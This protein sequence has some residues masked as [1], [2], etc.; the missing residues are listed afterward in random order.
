MR[1]KDIVSAAFRLERLDKVDSTN[2]YLK[3]RAAEGAP[4]GL[5]VVAE[6]QT[7]GRGRFGRSFHSPRGKGL[8][9]SILLRPDFLPAQAA[10]LTPWA[11][12][13]VCRALEKVTG[14]KP[15]IKWINDILLE[16]KK[17]CGILT[18]ADITPEGRLGYVIL[19]IGLNLTHGAEDFP[20]EVAHIATSLAQHL[21][22]TPD[23][24]AVL[25]AL[26]SELETMWKDFPEQGE[27]YLEAY[28][29][30]CSTVG[31]EI[32]ITSGSEG[33]EGFALG[34]NED[35]SL[36]VRLTDGSCQNLDSGMVSAR[37]KG[38]T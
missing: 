24:E 19:G 35:F 29:T 12:V 6:E 38:L 17:V 32:L 16:G 27:D 21:S 8:Y 2:N 5:A 10:G 22:S 14:L 26:L 18:E 1:E 15:E 30:R 9:L 33:K 20:P 31:Q 13:A 23:G 11:A 34:V 37:R 4:H 25:S 7:G 3:R 28:R 36:R